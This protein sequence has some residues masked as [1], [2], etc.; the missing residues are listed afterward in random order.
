RA[1]S[2]RAAPG[3]A[4]RRADQCARCRRPGTP[5]R[6]RRPPP[7]SGRHGRRRDPPESRL[8][9]CGNAPSRR[10]IA[11]MR[12]LLA[13]MR[14]DLRVSMR[15][16]GRFGLALVF[17]ISVVAIVPFAIGPDLDL[18]G[19]IGPAILWIG[20]LLASLSGLDRLFQPDYEDG[21]LD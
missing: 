12:A 14:R 5:W 11:M 17:F 6:P 13:L 4:A 2:R 20:A 8:A 18:L 16:G 10:R 19:R 21:T 3:L 15:A 9:G 7:P 1:P